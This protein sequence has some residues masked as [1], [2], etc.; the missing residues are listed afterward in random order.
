MLFWL[1]AIAVFAGDRFTKLLVTTNLNVG[2]SIPVIPGVLHITYVRN[3]GGA[4][5]FLPQGPLF[6]TAVTLVVFFAVIIYYLTRRPSGL[7]LTVALGLV[8]GGTAGNLVDRLTGGR[9]I[10][11][12]D[13]RIFPV[14]N[15]ADAALV[16][17]L[18]L[19][20]LQVLWPQHPNELIRSRPA[21]P[22]TD[23]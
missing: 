3:P 19:I 12:V 4:F 21:T 18:G 8:L 11:W 17:G 2:E 1:C 15:V 10:D 9:V 14:F 16:I 20:S 6:F 5:G 7:T 22:D 13:F 23:D